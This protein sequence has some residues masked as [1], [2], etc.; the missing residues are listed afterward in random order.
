MAMDFRQFGGVP[1]TQSMGI[2]DSQSLDDAIADPDAE[3]AWNFGINLARPERMGASSDVW[4]SQ[5]KTLSDKVMSGLP[6][7]VWDGKTPTYRMAMTKKIKHH[8]TPGA[9]LP[10]QFQPNG[11]CVGRGASGALNVFQALLCLHGFPLEWRPVSHAWC[12]AGAR[13]QYNDLGRGDG[14]VG[15]GAFEWCRGKGVTYQSEAGD[16]DYYKDGVAVKWA[17]TG[18]PSSI[19]ELGKD[20]PITDAF[21]VTTAAKA[22]DV[23]WSGGAVTVAS[24]RG[25][26]TTR[27]ADGFCAPR[28]VWN[29]QMHFVDVIVTAS[30]RKGLA[31][32]QSWGEDAQKGPKLAEQP[33]Y[34]FGVDMDVADA[35]LRQ[36]DSMGALNFDGWLDQLS[37]GI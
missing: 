4:E 20:N 33:G 25:F 3:I 37:W 9:F 10:A 13:M 34:V 22:C 7:K 1:L 35:M 12:Y 6:L 17:T 24:N 2:M 31:C 26:T 36:G 8:G 32:V 29:H 16:T 19:I 5:Q 21:P 15:K 27:D 30:G 23:L 14:A 11:T 18:I 28:G